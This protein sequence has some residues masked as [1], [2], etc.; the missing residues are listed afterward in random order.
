MRCRSET[1][2]AFGMYHL[3]SPV[4]LFGV[5]DALLVHV[6]SMYLPFF[7]DVLQTS[8]VSFGTWA[9]AIAVAL[10]VIPAMELHKW[11]WKRTSPICCLNPSG[12]R[13]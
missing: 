1:K 11:W 10:S 12:E 9:L 6:L 2:S 7:Q 4:L 8:S 3:R 13:P 5:H